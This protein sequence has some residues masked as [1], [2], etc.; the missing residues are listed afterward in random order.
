M[1]AQSVRNPLADTIFGLVSDIQDKVSSVQYL[2][3][4]TYV[5]FKI[6]NHKAQSEIKVWTTRRMSGALW[7][8][9]HRTSHSSLWV[10]GGSCQHMATRQLLLLPA[11]FPKPH[12][13]QFFLCLKNSII[14]RFY[15]TSGTSSEFFFIL[16]SRRRWLNSA[17]FPSSLYE[18]LKIL[19]SRI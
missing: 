11:R 6:P 15:F 2:S 1:V 3:K 19:D 16:G 4:S 10:Q 5:F 17:P 7:V 8:Q 14:I 18:S 12:S 9:N 13:E